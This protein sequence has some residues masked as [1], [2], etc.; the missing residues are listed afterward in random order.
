[1]DGLSDASKILVS[2]SLSYYSAAII[3]SICTFEHFAFPAFLISL[4][5]QIGYVL[6]IG[7]WYYLIL[8]NGFDIT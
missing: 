1:M 8:S 3:Q 2:D 7:I 4:L 5:L 6:S